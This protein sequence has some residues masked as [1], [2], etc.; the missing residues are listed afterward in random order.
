MTEGIG[1]VARGYETTSNEHVP[2]VPDHDV[3]VMSSPTRRDAWPSIGNDQGRRPRRH[4]GRIGG[5]PTCAWAARSASPEPA[6]P[7]PPGSLLD[8]TALAHL[9]T[10]GPTR[11]DR[12]WPATC[13]PCLPSSSRWTRPSHSSG[14]ASGLRWPPPR[15]VPRHA[16]LLDRHAPR[17]AAFAPRLDQANRALRDVR[18]R[19]AGQAPGWGVRSAIST[20]ATAA[21]SS[22]SELSPETPTAPSSTPSPSR[23]RTPPGTGTSEPPMAEAAAAMK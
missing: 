12:S 9:P 16:Q 21:S 3:F 19:L 17:V 6:D 22:W 11:S 14:A 15:P 2:R 1:F 23:T 8:P 20:P 7:Q 10:M 18:E 13:R 5:R 4:P